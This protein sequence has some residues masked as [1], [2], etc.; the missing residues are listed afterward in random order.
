M[1][2][3]FVA[4]LVF[5]VLL[6]SGKFP[7]FLTASKAKSDAMNNTPNKT[8]LLPTVPV[9]DLIPCHLKY[10]QFC[11]DVYVNKK[12]I[13]KLRPESLL[14]VYIGLDS[15]NQKRLRC[16]PFLAFQMRVTANFEIEQ[17]G[18]GFP[19]NDEA[20]AKEIMEIIKAK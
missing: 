18:D 5:M 1:G 8:D 7:A 14:G 9:N 6:T 3:Q 2:A 4:A 16:S 19:C 10:H 13:Y 20:R 12:E 15:E 17:M 11:A